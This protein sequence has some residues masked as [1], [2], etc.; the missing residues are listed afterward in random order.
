M[1]REDQ[2]M[3]VEVELPELWELERLCLWDVDLL[4][5]VRHQTLELQ[6]LH[7]HSTPP[8]IALR[9]RRTLTLPPTT[10]TI[11]TIT[12]TTRHCKKKRVKET[13][14]RRGRSC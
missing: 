6:T 5:W 10:I 14:W 4:L 8:L 2:T 11:T 1:K 12:I 7:L 9:R 13:K 3:D